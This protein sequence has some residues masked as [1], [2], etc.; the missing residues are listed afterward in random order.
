M[1]LTPTVGFGAVAR[2]A[3]P[4]Q[5]TRRISERRRSKRRRSEWWRPEWWRPEWRWP[6]WR[7]SE[8]RRR[9]SRTPWSKQ[10]H[11]QTNNDHS[12]LQRQRSHLHRLRW[13]YHR[14]CRRWKQSNGH[15]FFQ[16]HL[17]RRLQLQLLHQ[18]RIAQRPQRSLHARHHHPFEHW[19][20]RTWDLPIFRR[21]DLQPFV[22]CLPA[23][24]QYAKQLQTIPLQRPAMRLEQ[25][26][27]L[28]PESR[29]RDTQHLPTELFP[30]RSVGQ[31]GVQLM[32]VI[33]PEA[34][35]LGL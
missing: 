2:H 32:G 8:W 7:W 16:H 27:Q 25:R 6:E 14:H 22:Q 35:V 20:R 28:E 11:V 15:L 30:K 29:H 5:S 18:R 33:Q 9:P 34:L 19:Q 1:L 26:N 12:V 17:H 4:C 24:P 21:S 3:G 23:K 31:S 10:Q 13:H